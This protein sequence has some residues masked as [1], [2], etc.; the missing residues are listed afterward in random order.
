MKGFNL[1]FPVGYPDRHTP[2]E[3]R[4]AQRPK[5]YYNSN[6]DEDNN[7]NLNSVN[8][9]NS[10]SQ[11]FRQKPLRPDLLKCMNLPSGLAAAD[12]SGLYTGRPGI[13][14]CTQR[15]S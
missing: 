12:D 5:R 6:K 4:K 9:D 1:E 8:D 14:T 2:E 7:S 13:R 10:A 3:D 15:L 11:K